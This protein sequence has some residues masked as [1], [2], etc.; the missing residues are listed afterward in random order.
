M[1]N[2]FFTM[3]LLSAIS[4]NA[5]STT[6]LRP[7]YSRN[8]FWTETVINGSIKDK[9]KWQLDYQYRRGSEPS[10]VT[11]V[12]SNLFSNPFQHVYRPWIHYQMNDNVRLSLSPV[13]FWES[14][15]S[16]AE[17]NGIA[18]VQP[19]LRICPQVTLTNKIG[20]VTIDQR[21]RFEHRL[22]SNK[23]A[24]NGHEFDYSQGLD[25]PNTNTKGRMRYFVRA[26]VPLGKHQKLEDNTFYLIAW[27]EIFIG[28]GHNNPSYKVWDQNR[29]FCLL[30][31]KPKMNSSLPMRFEVGYGLQYA[32]RFTATTTNIEKN[33][34][35]QVYVIFENFNKVFKS[36]KK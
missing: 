24:Y 33:N 22:L 15:Y 35:L 32:N 12:K 27:N 8:T 10:T 23:T 20:R 16:A 26:I 5:Q 1:K 3:A 18:K 9:F 13:G 6:P 21:Y 2:I 29:T 14:Y 4:V 11:D 30:G 31:Y 34:I 28:T 25:F 7:T 17:G 19:E 36:N